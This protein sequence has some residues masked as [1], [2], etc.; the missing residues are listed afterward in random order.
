MYLKLLNI[1][2]NAADA[3]AL[4][5]RPLGGSLATLALLGSV[6]SAVATRVA[7]ARVVVKPH[8]VENGH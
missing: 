7:V 3:K 2:T 1:Y 6:A 4:R 8:D 5:A